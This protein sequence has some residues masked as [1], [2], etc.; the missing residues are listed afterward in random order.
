MAAQFGVEL[1]ILGPSPD[2]PI[3]IFT[4]HGPIREL[5][6]LAKGRPEQGSVFLFANAGD[7]EVTIQPFLSLVMG[8][9]F[10]ILAAFLVEAE[11]AASALW[12]VVFHLHIHHGANTGEAVDESGE[13]GPIPETNDM[14]RV[15]ALQ[16]L[17]GLL[18]SEGGGL[19]G[20]DD[21]LGATDS[22]CRVEGDDLANDH[23]V[24]E[25][26]DGGQMLF[27]GGRRG[28][29]HFDVGSHVDR[30][31]LLEVRK[32]DGLAP[33]KE[34]VAGSEVGRTGVLVADV[35][36]EELQIAIGCALT[37]LNDE[38]RPSL[39]LGQNELPMSLLGSWNDLISHDSRL[40]E[41]ASFGKALE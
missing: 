19:A 35:R 23:P 41:P 25:H 5:L 9:Y 8:R 10:V 29:E 27:H 39:A 4:S 36:G 24:E 12:E 18:G 34:A 3:D 20:L 6:G 21:M 1:C 15:D 32:L 26:A 40:P 31:D 28:F 37:S 16:Q 7:E 33:V 14:S 11:P 2:H 38:L 30:P 17:R 22:R 13:Q